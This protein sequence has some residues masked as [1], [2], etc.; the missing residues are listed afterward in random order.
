MT[1]IDL[2]IINASQVCTVPAHDSGPQ[3]GAKLG[4]VGLVENAAIAI[5]EGR[6]VEVGPAADVSSRYEPAETL[7]AGGRAVIPGLVDPHT[8][9]VWAGD[10]AAEF[11]QRLTGASYMEI[12]AAGGGIN[13]TVRET[14][15]AAVSDL[16]AET[17]PRLERMLSL[18]TTTVEIK[19]G[20]GL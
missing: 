12:M 7:D 19:T 3:R 4:D 15:A 2:L 17:R 14:R 5:R 1:S 11:E 10:R 9:L 20:Y 13:R 6:V 8:H 16:V 18:G